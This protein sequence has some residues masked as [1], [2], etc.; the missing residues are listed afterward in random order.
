MS[1]IRFILVAG[2]FVTGLTGSL[3][4]VR[5]HI[6][7]SPATDVDPTA[8]PDESATDGDEEGSE[9]VEAADEPEI[10][11]S[12]V[13]SALLEGP[14]NRPHLRRIAIDH[15]QWD[16]V[17]DPNFQEQAR[18]AL[19]RW[20]LDHPSL[21]ADAT[22]T[23]LAAEAAL[24]R[25]DLQQVLTLTADTPAIPMRLHRALALAQLGR[26][27]DA[28]PIFTELANTR[29]SNDPATADARDM[30]AVGQATLRL[31]EL[32]GRPA[33]DYHR[34]LNLF[35]Q[36]RD[37]IHRLHW[38]AAVA[39]A[40]L[41]MEK[42]NPEEAQEALGQA[43]TLNPRCG[44]AWYLLGSL[45]T[46]YFKFEQG[47]QCLQALRKIDSDH[48]LADLLE[49][50]LR[51]KQRD[52]ASADEILTRLLE[53]FP[54]QRE[55]LALHVATKALQYDPEALS[56]A[57]ARF[58]QI[59]PGNPMARVEAGIYLSSARQYDL[60]EA[61]LRSAL[62]RRPNDP[63]VRVE[64]GL[65]L[66]QSGDE[67]EAR[68]ELARAV[69][70]DPFN[71]RAINQLELAQQLADYHE[72]RTAH[73]R[74]RYDQAIDGV[75]ARDMARQL[76]QMR[77]E[78]VGAF[79]HPPAR[80]TLVEILPDQAHFAVRITG[81]P[82]IWT[83][84][85]CTGDVIAMTPPRE[86][87]Q[88]RGAFDWYRVMRHEYTH[89]V[90]LDQT[91]NRL[92]HWFTEACA[93]SQEPGGRDYGTY[94][95][96]AD[97]LHNDKLFTFEN[98]SWGFIRPTEAWHRPLAY[99]QSHWIYEFLV[100]H[101]GQA[102]IVDLLGR[103]RRG[104]PQTRAFTE[105]TG[106]SMEE[107]TRRFRKWAEAQTRDWGLAPRDDDE[108]VREALAENPDIDGLKALLDDHPDHPQILRRLAEKILTVE[109]FA[110]AGP[111]LYRYA[112]ARPVDPWPQQQ[113]ARAA[114]AGNDFNRAVG[115]LTELD[116][117][118]QSTGRWSHQLA[119][120]HRRLDRPQEARDAA[121]RALQREPYNPAYREL[122]ATLAL[123]TGDMEAAL[124]HLEA[125]PLLEPDR[126]LH[127]V[128]LAAI[129][130]R[131]GRH[132]QARAAAEEALAIDPRAPVQRYLTDPV[133]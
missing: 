15:G 68:V 5:A 19:H 93:V 80:P 10:E 63:R 56:R 102:L 6:Q 62:K 106:L 14:L 34:A 92:P 109:G 54:R 119:R 78:V 65:M 38:P 94:R 42:Q 128:R 105:A 9:A 71:V 113:F 127:Q 39:E 1:L 50:R 117:K 81:I 87:P 131:L 110:A 100:A 7:V 84:A 118:T 31:A 21:N 29:L 64:L 85:A 125:L 40:E 45:A 17:E 96:L 67:A 77:A 23:D 86:G 20:Q 97:A 22:P 18:I 83:I 112:E 4:P 120:I 13:V 133:D 98:I 58:D 73:F 16:R 49:A 111:W 33:R 95:L 2:L 75:L 8:D 59:S 89:T 99:A 104:Q 90:T 53:R 69:E 47:R 116:R 36:A 26:D 3:D 37:Q 57:L 60:S 24:R 55:A 66:M 46:R 12:P 61:M 122:A 101:W 72:I 130:H 126:A 52:P 35:T 74:I 132:D 27:D 115:P 48:P 129:Y 88:Q 25:G 28:R 82:E 103:F 32:D 107:L 91:R 76:E 114:L 121:R 51:L 44:R 124:F 43:L 41:L 123:E 108:A 11:L 79:E 30:V 70:L